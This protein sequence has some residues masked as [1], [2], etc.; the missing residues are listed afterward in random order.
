MRKFISQTFAALS[1]A[2]LTSGA[3]FAAGITP[4][5]AFSGIGTITFSFGPTTV[6]C[7]ANFTGTVDADGTAE[8]TAVS[9]TGGSFCPLVHVAALPW[10]VT[11]AG[12]TSGE[13]AGMA[14]S[15]PFGSCGPSP[16]NFSWS[17]S[18]SELTMNN[19]P[20]SGGCH[21]TGTLTTTPSLVFTP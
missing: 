5:G 20:L 8:V 7:T 4:T 12:T 18:T 1:L 2:A 6:S 19:V 21:V 13:I 9:I 10:K 15:S 17:N 11:A 14:I 3:A 16:V